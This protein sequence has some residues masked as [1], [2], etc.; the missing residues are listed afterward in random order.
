MTPES[1]FGQSGQ[2]IRGD[3]SGHAALLSAVF[4]IGAGGCS[5]DVRWCAASAGGFAS[6]GAITWAR[7]DTRVVAAG[8]RAL[9]IA[10][11]K[12]GLAVKIRSEERRVG[13]EWFSTCR[14]RL[15]PYS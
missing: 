10:R 11:A 13:K 3:E 6:V 1:R 15:S 14:A 7:A 5:C 12:P 9:G 2:A 8:V 4:R